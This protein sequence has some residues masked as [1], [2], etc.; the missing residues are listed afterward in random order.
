[1]KIYSTTIGS[2]KNIVL[3]HGWGFSS[4]IFFPFSETLAKKYRITLIDFPGF[5]QSQIIENYN[6]ENIVESIYPYIPS[7]AILIGWSLGGL[8]SIK[9]ALQYTTKFKKIITIVT[10]PC[11]ISNKGWPGTCKKTFQAF[12]AKLAKDPEKTLLEF[13]LLQTKSSMNQKQAYHRL[14]KIIFEEKLPKLNALEAGL[15]ILKHTDL[16][17]SLKTFSNP[18][19]FILSDNDPLVPLE[20]G[21]KI[22]NLNNLIEITVI[23]NG[24]HAPFLFC[25]EE[26]INCITNFIN[27]NRAN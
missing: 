10:N 15:K 22:N 11:F 21:I 24:A 26:T 18:I 5:G 9:L 1:M 13:I 17:E 25:Q 8:V 12:E 2:G 3:L 27:A 14:K 7:D 19:L 16:S 20:V 23:K 6:L 4:T